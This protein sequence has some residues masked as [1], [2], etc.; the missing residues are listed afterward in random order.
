ML[1]QF[2]DRGLQLPTG[3]IRDRIKQQNLLIRLAK[4]LKAPAPQSSSD[5]SSLMLCSHLT[6]AFASTSM[7]K[8]NTASMVIQT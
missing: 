3:R 5:T 1:K 6:S 7:S 4:G 2:Q 8:L